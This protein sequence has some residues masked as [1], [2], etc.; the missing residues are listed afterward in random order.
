MAHWQNKNVWLTDPH[1][2]S[3]RYSGYEQLGTQGDGYL[4]TAYKC[5]RGKFEPAP[6][7]PNGAYQPVVDV[8]NM[9]VFTALYNNGSDAYPAARNKAWSAMVKSVRSNPAALGVALAEWPK[10]CIMV[11]NRA[12]RLY[13]SYRD[14]RQGHFRSFLKDLGIPPKRSHRNWITT[15]TN[16][17]SGLFLEYSFG[18][19]PAVQDIYAGVHTLGQPLPGGSCSGSGRQ[20]L[21]S[22]TGTSNQ[23]TFVGTAYVKQGGIF[24]VSNPNTFALQQL[25]L[26][27]PAQ[28]AW[29][30]VP[31][32]F[33]VDWVF[34]VGTFLG[35]F[36]DLLG[37]S[38]TGTYNTA[39]IKGRGTA[40]WIQSGVPYYNRGIASGVNRR[41]GLSKPVPNFAFTANI[42]SSLNRAA[43][44]VSLLGQI[45]TK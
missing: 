29:E 15:R 11:A 5:R 44:A 17:A 28:I 30:L 14:L 24:T 4:P 8:P 32:S 45:L 34:D 43:N 27:N 25:G 3:T 38:V 6:R 13:N 10:T 19:K 26:A 39:F 33:L 7:L 40:R 31:F 21:S 22:V 20:S 2:S 1:S 16:Q 18:W 41:K 42:G 36:T 35:G 12:T 23:M 37:C 9:A